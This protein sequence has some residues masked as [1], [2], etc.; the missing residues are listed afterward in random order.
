MKTATPQDFKIESLPHRHVTINVNLSYSN[1]QKKKIIKGFI[2]KAME[3]KWFIFFDRGILNFH[4]SW[5]GFCVYRVYCREEDNK[6]FLTHA[7]VNRDPEQYKETNDD[8]DQQMI[9]FLVNVLLLKNQDRFPSNDG[10]E[11]DPLKAWS[12]IGKAIDSIKPPKN[13]STDFVRIIPVQQFAGYPAPIHRPYAFY[14]DA[15]S[16]SGRTI[17]D[18]YALVKGIGLPPMECGL[19]HCS[20]FLWS[21]NPEGNYDAPISNIKVKRK[22]SVI[23][24]CLPE[25]D[26]EKA[27]YLV[28]Q[29]SRFDAIRNLDVF[30]ATWRAL[31][32]IIS[33]P[34]RM[35]ANK[36]AWQMSISDYASARLHELFKDVQADNA[37]GLLALNESKEGLRLT[38]LDQLPDKNEEAD[39]YAY[40]SRNSAFTDR[41]I[42]LFGLSSRCW[43]GC[44]YLG[45]PGKPICRFYLLRNVM[46]PEMKIR[47]M[48]GKDRFPDF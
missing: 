8:F 40:L 27:K 33:D 35:G 28:L 45:S 46:I 25:K 19:K 31:S 12:S 11:P 37:K 5:T 14:T 38:D 1:I 7:D 2:P 21:D 43:H 16:L 36:P 18:S 44:G 47:L 39:Y 42:D 20:P 13:L 22:K 10:S 9:S 48:K 24:E 26:L 30:P 15:E 4:R 41:I 32:Y 6:F 17:A 34:E 29:I 3:D 23:F